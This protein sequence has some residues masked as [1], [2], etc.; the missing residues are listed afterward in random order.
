MISRKN[1]WFISMHSVED[2]QKNLE[3]TKSVDEKLKLCIEA[4][5]GSLSSSSSPNFKLFWDVRSKCMDYFKNPEVTHAL[6][7]QLWNEYIELTQQAR[8]LK[9]ILD[10]QSSFEVE[11]I[12]KAIEALEENVDYL[13]EHRNFEPLKL[14]SKPK[15]LSEVIRELA[16]EQALVEQLNTRITQLE[17]LRNELQKVEIRL[18]VR[19]KLYKHLSKIGDK[20][21]PKKK[22]LTKSIS[23]AY[24]DSIQA[25]IKDHPLNTSRKPSLAFLREEIKLFQMLSK[26]LSL[27]TQAFKKSRDLLSK[28]WDS[29]KEEGQKLKENREKKKGLYQENLKKI[30]EK[31]QSFAE[32]FKSNSLSEGDAK[33][34][35]KE[36][37]SL[38][39]DLELGPD[40][41]KVARA[42]VNGVKGLMVSKEERQEQE[43]RDRISNELRH[44][45]EKQE[46]LKTQIEAFRSQIEKNFDEALFGSWHELNVA[47]KNSAIL[48]SELVLIEHYHQI[49]FD[50][51]LQRQ[52]KEAN[53]D[54]FLSSLQEWKQAIALQY[55]QWKKHCGSSGLDFEKAIAYNEELDIAKKRLKW[56]EKEI[57]SFEGKK[58]SKS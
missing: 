51:L 58:L 49:S 39:K 47:L 36:L 43:K 14:S 1:Q 35:F 27:S 44:R 8:S 3:N 7:G 23:T 30:L 24:I 10:E 46:E 26:E 4:M 31:A 33:R 9:K 48:E 11:Q 53:S 18:G 50:A 42:E 12:S 15:S 20:L 21:F 6:K 5:K 29:I 25:F 45:E 56:I 16:F 2:F 22:E 37:T 28:F 57:K 13:L 19:N 54:D 32:S 40:E 38:F 41:L 34:L 55:E 17:A 52:A